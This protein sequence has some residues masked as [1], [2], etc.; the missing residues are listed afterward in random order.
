[1]KKSEEKLE[2]HFRPRATE[3]VS[4]KIPKESLYSLKEIAA[5]RDMS[6]KALLKFYIGQGLRQDLAKIF[7]ERVLDTTEKETKAMKTRIKTLVVLV[8]GLSL[9]LSISVQGQEATASSNQTGGM[10]YF[11]LGGGK[12]DIDALNTQLESTGHSTLSD[13]FISFGG[14]GH[15]LKGRLIIGG[16]GHGLS[17]Q[18]TESGDYTIAIGA[19]YGFF[20]IGY[21][22]YSTGTL[23]LYPILGIGGG[24]LSVRIMEK[25]T[26]PSFNQ[27]LN[28]PKRGV[29]L[30]TGGWLLNLALG[31]D[32]IF[33]ME[34]DKRGQGGFALGLR[35]GYVF[36][37][38]KGDWA[39][40]GM[41]ISG[42]P[43]LGI[44]GP[45]IRLMIG[46]GGF[47]VR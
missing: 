39:M 43:D 26:S 41:D 1:M 21:S 11:M 27:V 31:T 25:G 44:T 15:S 5:K 9:L 45:Y 47:G 19:G 37:P 16:E 4:I 35:I 17:A 20:N 3:T 23:N 38:I 8:A 34:K 18:D 7:A 6:Y 28:N 24:G 42:G 14:G 33:A 46:G 2:L 10:G 13:N 22:L 30:S 12:L 36:A 32:Y 29:D 40:D